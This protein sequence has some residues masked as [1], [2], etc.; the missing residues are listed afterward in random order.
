M[1]VH[2]V[3]TASVLATHVSPGDHKIA[4]D[5]EDVSRMN[6]KEITTIMVR[7]SEFERVLVLT[8]LAAPKIAVARVSYS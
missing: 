8:L 2:E 3:G 6:L 1:V 5:D 4:I 7:K